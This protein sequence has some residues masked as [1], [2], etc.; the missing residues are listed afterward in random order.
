MPAA[1]GAAVANYF[2]F[3]VIGATVASAAVL[4]AVVTV[5]AT[6]ALNLA[7]STAMARGRGGSP[8]VG[9]QLLSATIRQAAAARRLVYGEVKVGGILTYAAQSADGEYAY[10]CIA[11]GE[12]PMQGIDPV[13]YLGDEKSDAAKFAGLVQVEFFDGTQTT[14][15]STLIAAGGYLLGVLHGR[16]MNE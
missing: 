16:K 12:G 7:L 15:S 13:I 8:T 6:V 2:A 11:L 10:L 14:A 1:I 4:Q 5:A 9:S 3:N